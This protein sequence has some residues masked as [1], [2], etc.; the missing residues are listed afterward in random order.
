MEE[1]T[2]HQ[3]YED[4]GWEDLLYRYS[5]YEVKIGEVHLSDGDKIRGYVV[6]N[7]ETGVVEHEGRELW[8]AAAKA[9]LLEKNL[10]EIEA[11][12]KDDAEADDDDEDLDWPEPAESSKPN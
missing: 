6:V 7:S 8:Y 3:D 1:R 5:R 9:R 2:I 12:Y 10:A 4:D 11:R